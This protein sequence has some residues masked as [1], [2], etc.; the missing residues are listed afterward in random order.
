MPPQGRWDAGH[1]ASLRDRASGWGE[2]Q[3][4]VFYFLRAISLS[5]FPFYLSFVCSP[6]ISFLILFPYILS[7]NFLLSAFCSVVVYWTTLSVNIHSLIFYI[8]ISF[9]ILSSLAICL[10]FVPLFLP[11]P[12]SAS[13]FSCS[14]IRHFSI[15]VS[16]FFLFHLPVRFLVVLCF[17]LLPSSA[18]SPSS[19]PAAF[20]L[21]RLC[22]CLFSPPFHS[23]SDSFPGCKLTGAWSWLFSPSSSEF[24]GMS[25]VMPAT[26]TDTTSRVTSFVFFFR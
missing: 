7:R 3:Q 17:C 1:T 24:E 8:F 25:G 6:C 11:M 20:K 26:C 10:L 15:V 21:L 5:F 18:A 12:H 19:S 23:T 16:S 13:F 2:R 4:F 22:T 9:F 14:I